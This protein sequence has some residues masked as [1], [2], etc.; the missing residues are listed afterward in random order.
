[1][2]AQGMP[3]VR[4]Y[5]QPPGLAI[6][7]LFTINPDSAAICPVTPIWNGQGTAGK[8]NRCIGG[9]MGLAADANFIQ[10]KILNRAKGPMFIL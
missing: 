6:R 2:L 1:M 9:E 4:R 3:D 7:Q 10:S 5:R 8:R